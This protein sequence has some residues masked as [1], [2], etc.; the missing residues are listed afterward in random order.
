ML[1]LQLS[2]GV[3]ANEDF[4]FEGRHRERYRFF[5]DAEQFSRNGN[6]QSGALGVQVVRFMLVKT[7][8]HVRGTGCRSRL[9]R[10][11]RRREVQGVGVGEVA[12]GQLVAFGT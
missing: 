8:R 1:R 10:R 4:V 12:I 2:P 3:V 7:G 11:R 6:D 9:P 5:A